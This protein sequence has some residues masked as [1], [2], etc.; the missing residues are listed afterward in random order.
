[1]T[2][3]NPA[4]SHGF[5]SDVMC[6]L[7]AVSTPEA[8]CLLSHRGGCLLRVHDQQARAYC[9][10][11]HLTTHADARCCKLM[12]C[13]CWCLSTGATDK[14]Q[15]LDVAGALGDAKSKGEGACWREF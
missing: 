4:S 2:D 10:S 6:C 9:W 1:M 11:F 12:S 8:M 15:D 13:G 7:W 14:L 3:T 5:D